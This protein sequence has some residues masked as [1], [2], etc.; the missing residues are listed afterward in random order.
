M[1]DAAYLRLKARLCRE[2]AD[3]AILPEVR[4]QLALFADEFDARRS[5]GSNWCTG[6][7]EG[8]GDMLT[9]DGSALVEDTEGWLRELRE[10]RRQAISRN[11]MVLAEELRAEIAAAA[12]LLDRAYEAATR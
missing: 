6:G 11:D 12:T 5:P 9:P 8:G 1:V 7:S 4:E 10:L 3:V 2:L